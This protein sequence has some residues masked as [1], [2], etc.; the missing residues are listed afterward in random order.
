M[1]P[2]FR[3]YSIFILF[4]LIASCSGPVE[5]TGQFTVYPNPTPGY[6][7]LLI[8]L[9][10]DSRV[11][12]QLIGGE[13][14]AQ[15]SMMGLLIGN[16][17]LLDTLLVRGTHDFQIDLSHKPNGLYLLDASINGAAKRIKLIKI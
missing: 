9:D 6:A 11:V 17:P 1:K 13:A 16:N 2:P 7:N 3:L 12:L 10:D 14:K 15:N 4:L 8:Q 5:F